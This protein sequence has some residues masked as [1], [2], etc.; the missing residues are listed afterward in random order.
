M[1]LLSQES[2]PLPEVDLL[3]FVFGNTDYDNDKPVRTTHLM[4]N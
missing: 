1:P 2:Y 4:V 3:T